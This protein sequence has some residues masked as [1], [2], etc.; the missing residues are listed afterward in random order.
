MQVPSQ[1]DPQGGGT[2]NAPQAMPSEAHQLMALA[3]MH[4]QGRFVPSTF[5]EKWE[6]TPDV[7]THITN[8]AQ[9]YGF[10]PAT[11][12]A[13]ADIES[14]GNPNSNKGNLTNS[15]KGLFQLGK[16]EWNENKPDSG[17]IY[18]A[19]DNADAAGKL[20][21]GHRDWFEQ[22]FGHDPSDAELYMMHQQGRGF[23]TKGTLI[24]ARG[25]PYPGMRGSQTPESFIAGWG[26]ELEKRK[27][28]FKGDSGV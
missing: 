13:I 12:Q 2:S 11:L 17:D 23:F 15:H 4:A 25:N 18:S 28:Q 6:G 19:R 1:P 22:R 10:N 14:S 16:D 5:D 27:Q 24:N 7:A 3:T 20:L 21:A 9:K 26:R 8:S